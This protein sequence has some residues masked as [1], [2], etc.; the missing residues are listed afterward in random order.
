MQWVSGLSEIGLVV[1]VAL[2]GYRHVRWSWVGGACTVPLLQVII[3]PPIHTTFASIIHLVHAY[4][5]EAPL[6]RLTYCQIAHRSLPNLYYT[7]HTYFLT[8]NYKYKHLPLSWVL[9]EQQEI[10]PGSTSAD[11]EVLIGI[12]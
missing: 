1:M 11:E 8:T 7:L 5:V 2:I 3:I 6:V 12:D 4:Y 9:P 10:G